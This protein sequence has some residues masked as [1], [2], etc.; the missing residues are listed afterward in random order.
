MAERAND[1]EELTVYFYALY[2]EGDKHAHSGLT[3]NCCTASVKDDIAHNDLLPRYIT[4]HRVP[5][6]V[7]YVDSATGQVSIVERHPQ[8]VSQ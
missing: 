3:A 2:D 6:L 1:M 5:G 4:V 8:E 7:G